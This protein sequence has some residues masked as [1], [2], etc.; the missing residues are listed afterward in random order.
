[1]NLSKRCILAALALFGATAPL[2]AGLVSVAEIT[3]LR[4]NTCFQICTEADK[5]KIESELGAEARAYPKALEETKKAWQL[6]S[7]NAAFPNNRLKPRTLR[8]LT[9]TVNREEADRALAQS[10]GREERARASK[11]EE[12][13]KI[14]NMRVMRSRRG[15]NQAAVEQQQRKVKEDREKEAAAD[16]AEAILRQKLSALAGHDVPFYGETPVDDQNAEPKKKKKKK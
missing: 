13:E 12:E 1:M 11:K 8:I 2:R 3:D 16:K 4:G 5:L 9:T 7:A 15:N 6:D 10:K 14:L